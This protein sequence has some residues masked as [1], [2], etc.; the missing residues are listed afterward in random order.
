EV[1]SNL[2]VSVAQHYKDRGGYDVH[3]DISHHDVVHDATIRNLQG[4]PGNSG[5]PHFIVFDEDVAKASRRIRAHLD[6]IANTAHLVVAND[7]VA[8][9]LLCIPFQTDGVILCVNVAV[10]DNE[11][12]DI[13]HV[14][15]VGVENVVIFY[16]NVIDVYVLAFRI[17]L[18]PHS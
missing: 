15:A 13:E 9:T 10:L 11:A 7:A 5:M 16:S 8:A 12:V 6:A 4:K 17:R 14:T 2:P 3:L 1:A 18:C